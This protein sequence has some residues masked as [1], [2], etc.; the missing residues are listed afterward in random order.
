MAVASGC[1]DASRC[2]LGRFSNGAKFFQHLRGSQGQTRFH[3]WNGGRNAHIDL[4]EEMPALGFTKRPG[5][6]AEGLLEKVVP[7]ETQ[8]CPLGEMGRGNDVVGSA[9]GGHLLV[10]LAQSANPRDL[11]VRDR[12]QVRREKLRRQR[13]GGTRQIRCQYTRHVDRFALATPSPR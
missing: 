1:S 9:A 3:T 6:L 8:L 4:L 12:A 7:Q 10:D 11:C 13:L 5:V 2:T